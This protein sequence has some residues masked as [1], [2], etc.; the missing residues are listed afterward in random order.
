MQLA[1]KSAKRI[2]YIMHKGR[3]GWKAS[4]FHERDICTTDAWF[5]PH[6][7]SKLVFSPRTCTYTIVSK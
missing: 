1:L 2:C 6:T 4:E 5:N 7:C 3:A